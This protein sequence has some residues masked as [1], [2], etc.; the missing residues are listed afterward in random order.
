[1]VVVMILDSF[2]GYNG[3]YFPEKI[4]KRVAMDILECPHGDGDNCVRC[5]MNSLEAPN[6]IYVP[7]D[8]RDIK[9]CVLKL[10]DE[11]KIG[12]KSNPNKL[13]LAGGYI[14]ATIANE[15]VNDYD[16]FISGSETEAMVISR[17]MGY[18]KAVIS[19]NAITFNL[20]PSNEHP[21]QFV[22]RW[23]FNNPEELLNSFDLTIAKAAI[24]YDGKDWKGT[25][26][27]RFYQDLA[28][29]RLCYNLA[30]PE[31]RGA[32]HIARLLKFISRGSG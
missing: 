13:I 31:G 30:V 1:M 21:T 29:K 17:N 26:S 27:E 9:A 22:Y 2:F 28:A 5:A 24:W 20:V 18:R 19:E 23:K 3:K 6:P 4:E 15:Q 14:R 25:C 32:S 16:L 7:L 11:I 10:P 8:E 12:L